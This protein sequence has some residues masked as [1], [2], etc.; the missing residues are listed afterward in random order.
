MNKNMWLFCGVVVI[1]VA[2][3][4]FYWFYGSRQTT[5]IQ[6]AQTTSASNLKTYIDFERGFTFSYPASDSITVQPSKI[7]IKDSGNNSLE[8]DIVISGA[9]FTAAGF[10]QDMI[11]NGQNVSQ[12]PITVNGASGIDAQLDT[13]AKQPYVREVYLQNASGSVVVGISYSLIGD[14]SFLAG[15]NEIVSSFQFIQ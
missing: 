13:T 4:L 10:I 14:P 6:P 15:G 8:Y 7:S 1:L 9:P 3:G 5:P 2:S 12:K 11:Q